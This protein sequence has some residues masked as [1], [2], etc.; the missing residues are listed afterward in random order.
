MRFSCTIM[1]LSINMS[2]SKIPST[3]SLIQSVQMAISL[4]KP[5]CL[6]Y[7]QA[8]CKKQC[9]IGRDGP[10]GD[11]FLYKNEE[12]YTSPLR[13]MFKIESG[14]GNIVD[15]FILETENS[16]YIISGTMFS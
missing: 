3:K 15:D 4:E 5:I 1:I 16:I 10:D 2:D 6:D 14:D 8:S 11:K 12:E 9:K 13:S 7:Y